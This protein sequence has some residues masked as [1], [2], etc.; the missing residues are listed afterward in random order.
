MPKAIVTRYL[1]PTNGKGARIAARCDAKRIVITWPGE[2]D[3]VD[4]APKAHEVAATELR[5]ALGWEG[6]WIGGS[7]PPDGKDSYAFVLREAGK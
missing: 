6:E 7:L 5:R 2:F 3:D 4:D 1:P